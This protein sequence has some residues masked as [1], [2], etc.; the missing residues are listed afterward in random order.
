MSIL[1]PTKTNFS[2]SHGGSINFPPLTY[3]MGKSSIS[4][5]FR[6]LKTLNRLIRST[7]RIL[8]ITTPLPKL[9]PGSLTNNLQILVQFA[10]RTQRASKDNLST[11]SRGQS[12]IPNNCALQS[13]TTGTQLIAEK[14]VP[15]Y[16]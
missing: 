1:Y 3:S 7:F 6:Q 15:K 2:K 16:D 13:S 10:R 5:E 11:H 12:S 14:I 9:C 4:A 8:N